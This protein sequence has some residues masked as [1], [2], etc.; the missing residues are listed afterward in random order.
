MFAYIAPTSEFKTQN[1]TI[2]STPMRWATDSSHFRYSLAIFVRALLAGMETL[3]SAIFAQM[4]NIIVSNF[5]KN[6]HQQIYFQGETL[7]GS[8][9]H[10]LWVGTLQG[11][12]WGSCHRKRYQKRK[13]ITKTKRNKQYRMISQENGQL[14]QIISVGMP[15]FG[16]L[17]YNS[18]PKIGIT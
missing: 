16:L 11:R 3:S 2:W 1:W 10:S 12:W 4:Q 7:D 8:K 17:W 14:Y 18:R 9:A 15:C 5:L 6:S 13:Q